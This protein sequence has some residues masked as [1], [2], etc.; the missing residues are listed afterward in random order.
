M[1]KDLEGE[2]CV[3][4]CRISYLWYM[5]PIYQRHVQ[6]QLRTYQWSFWKNA[7]KFGYDTIF[8]ELYTILN[9]TPCNNER[10][11]LVGILAKQPRLNTWTATLFAS[12][13]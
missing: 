3:K 2:K 10:G 6:R 1:S 13:N 8:D 12:L 5:Q 4:P 11:S 7:C 9:N